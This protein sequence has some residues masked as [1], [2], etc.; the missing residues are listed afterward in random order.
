[1]IKQRVVSLS[2]SFVDSYI[3]KTCLSYVFLFL[4][5]G[6]FFISYPVTVE[7]NLILCMS[8]QKKDLLFGKLL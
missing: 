5:W 6:I 3:S 8:K 1:M 4:L 7:N 2:I